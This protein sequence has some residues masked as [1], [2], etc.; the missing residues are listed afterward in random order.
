MKNKLIIIGIVL[1]LIVFVGFF[2]FT[3][4]KKIS[5]NESF[6]EET[7]ELVEDIDQNDNLIPEGNDVEEVSNE[8]TIERS[9]THSGIILPISENDLYPY[10]SSNPPGPDYDLY[11]IS[12]DGF[13]PN[14]IQYQ[15]STGIAQLDKDECSINNS[16]ISGYIESNEI[17]QVDGQNFIKS[18]SSDNAMNQQ[19]KITRYNQKLLS[20]QCRFIKIYR[21][22][23]NPGAHSGDIDELK[24]NNEISTELKLKN[25]EFHIH[26]YNLVYICNKINITNYFCQVSH[27]LFDDSDDITNLDDDASVGSIEF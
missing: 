21:Y 2:Y 16:T 14:T 11:L 17:V 7:F 27:Y 23:S 19:W 9:A 18:I 26:K 10:G 1:L 13:R 6:T 3:N 12:D 8:K 5:N 4:E 20:N 25:I 22:S 24:E 15:I